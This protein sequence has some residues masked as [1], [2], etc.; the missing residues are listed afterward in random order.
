[1]KNKNPRYDIVENTPELVCIKDIGPWDQHLTVTNGAEIVVKELAK[2]LNGR[3]LEYYDSDNRR[4]E[5]LVCNG[6]FNGFASIPQNK[7][8]ILTT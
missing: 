5:L 4:D 2:Y 6:E 1:M 3:R 8:D 7:L